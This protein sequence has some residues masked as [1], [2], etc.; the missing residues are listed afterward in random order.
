MEA[1]PF[2]ISGCSLQLVSVRQTPKTTT[3]RRTARSQLVRCNMPSASVPIINDKALADLISSLIARIIHVQP[4][5]DITA[6]IG[7]DRI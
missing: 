5:E 1:G 2:C 4:W 7:E 3:G 6:G